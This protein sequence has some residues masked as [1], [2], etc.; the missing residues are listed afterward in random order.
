[1]LALLLAAVAVIVVLHL[2]GDRFGIPASALLTVAGLVYGLSPTPVVPL[3][4]ELILTFVLPP[5]L[6]SAA[7]RASLIEIRRSL[8]VVISLSV[9][10]VLVTALVVGLGMSWFLPGVGLAAGVALGGAVAPP[11]PVASLS[12]GRRAGLPGRLIN[13]IEGEGLLNDATALTILTVA[14]SAV[15]SGTFSFPQAT[16]RF[17][18]LAAGGVAVGVAT[19]YLI[20]LLRRFIRDSVPVNCI[21]LA[22][23]FFA[24]LVAE[25]IH[26][27]GVLAVVVAGLIIGH[28]TPR[29]T[30]AQSR[31]QTNAVWRLVDMLLEGFVFLL[32]GEQLPVIIRALHDETSHDIILASVVVLGA[33]LLV[34]PLWLLLTQSLPRVLHT[35]LGGLR[36]GERHPSDVG[37]SLPELLVLS[38]AGTRGVIT[39][40]AI[41]TL[42]LTTASGAPFPERD[43]LLYCAYLVVLVTLVLQGLTFA[44]LVRAL[45]LEPDD[46]ESARV[47]NEARLAAIHAAELRLGELI[48][49]HLVDDATAA[50][51]RDSL[52]KRANRYRGRLDVLQGA[53]GGGVPTTPQY[54]QALRA[55]RQIIGAERDELLRWRDA[56]RLPESELRVLET[57][58]DLQ[59]GVLP[60]RGRN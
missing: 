35:R 15:V 43:L 31:L 29:Y 54:E 37:L 33:V 3:D 26:V 20:R 25:Q 47:R 8:R 22:T 60:D 38:W 2:V 1:M 16:L 46:L 56:G 52:E 27:S 34:R 36:T 44:P 23:P 5:L 7:I 57:E 55:R 30:N 50:G 48:D 18:I 41:F 13:I 51:L 4:P 19:A 6:Y 40:A 32:I 14:V 45:K 42:P 59:E 17:V 11:D 24:Y 9:L 53:D 58:L 10:L 49:Q 21:S 28:D 39:L 12:V